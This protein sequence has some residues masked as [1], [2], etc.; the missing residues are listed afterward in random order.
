MG[1]VTIDGEV[2]VSDSV[3]L[4][5][6]AAYLINPLIAQ[7]SFS[8]Q[9]GRGGNLLQKPILDQLLALKDLPLK[10]KI[11]VSMVSPRTQEKTTVTTTFDVTSVST[12]SISDNLFKVP[13]DYTEVDPP[14]PAWGGGN[15][16]GGQG[17]PGGGGPGGPGGDA[18]AV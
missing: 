6:T 16:G 3:P 5:S 10:S 1:P 12:A 15:R 14:A 17:G 2:W 13:D 7:L 8:G 9:G 18:A 4:P 11:S